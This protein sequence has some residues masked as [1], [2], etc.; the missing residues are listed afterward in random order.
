MVLHRAYL[1]RQLPLPPATK[2]PRRFTSDELRVWNLIA[3]RPTPIGAAGAPARA[4][5]KALMQKT[6]ATS[7]EHLVRLGHQYRLLTG[8]DETP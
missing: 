8:P 2:A 4:A 5:I 3:T 6:G 7:E 1:K